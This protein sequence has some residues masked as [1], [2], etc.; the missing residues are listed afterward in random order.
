MANFKK[1]FPEATSEK[2]S[3][4]SKTGYVSFLNNGRKANA[5]FN[6]KGKLNYLITEC[7]VEHL[8]MEFRQS[9]RSNYSNYQL[10]YASEIKS[11]GVVIYE[12]ILECS[13]N[14]MTLRFTEEGVEEIKT[15]IK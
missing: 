4:T 8:P 12:A 7:K 10:Y 3:A 2:W 6:A 5:S 1:L 11:N 14:F 13:S 15:V 9:I